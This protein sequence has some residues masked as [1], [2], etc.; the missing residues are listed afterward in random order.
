MVTIGLLK[1][2]KVGR[3]NFYINSQLMAL[4]LERA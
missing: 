3:S 2:T 4:F 1:K